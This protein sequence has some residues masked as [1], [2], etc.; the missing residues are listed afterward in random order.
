MSSIVVLDSSPVGRIVH[1][2]KF[3]DIT[4]WF[5]DVVVSGR[6]VVLPEIIDYEV[7]RGLLRIPSTRQL[8][9]LDSIKQG[10]YYD[11]LTTEVMMDAADVWAEAR[12]MDR[13]FT[14]DDRLDGDAIFVAQA[15]GLGDRRSVTAIT[16]NE[17]HLTPFLTVSRWQDFA[18]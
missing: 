17:K 16:E 7:R 3:R 14:S 4:A 2:S 9:N 11:P 18:P 12:N 5:R 8:Q 1:P 13:P 15:R 6:R 10:V